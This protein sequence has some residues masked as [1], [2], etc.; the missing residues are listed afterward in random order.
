MPI[1][2]IYSYPATAAAFENHWGAV[3]EALAAPLV[4]PDGMALADFAARVEQMNAALAAIAPAVSQERAVAADLALKRAAITPRMAQ[5]GQAVRLFLANTRFAGAAPR[6]P[7]PSDGEQKFKQ[8]TQ[9]IQARW[10]DINGAT[11]LAPFTPPLVLPPDSSAQPPAASYT[12]AAFSAEAASL[13]DAFA[14]DRLAGDAATQK[15]RDRDALLPPI[16]EAMKTYR[17]ACLLLLPA[18]SPLRA[19]LPRLTPAP[20]TTPPAL[21]VSGEWDAQVLMAHL[22]WPATTAPDA[23]KLQVRGCVGAYK[24]ADEEVVADLDAH[25]TDWQGDWGLSEPGSTVSFKVYVVATTGNENGGKPVK[26][27]RPAT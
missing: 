23:A 1:T 21:I 24:A 7:S 16:H 17:E 4:L 15:R 3:N 18:D 25:N 20:G 27:M 8:A 10:N 9:T 2:G 26:I 19:T 5:F 13:S 12:L 22:T 6:T 11:D 14:A